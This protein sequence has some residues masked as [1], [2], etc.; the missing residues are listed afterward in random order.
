MR[1]ILIKELNHSERIASIDSLRLFAFLLVFLYHSKSLFPLTGWVGV[2][3]F[4]VISG[5]VVT[6]SVV[7]SDGTIPPSFDGKRFLKRRIRRLF[8]ASAMVLILTTPWVWY[9]SLPSERSGL[10]RSTVSGL[11]GF[12]N[13]SQLFGKGDY[14]SPENPSSFFHFWSLG[15]EE[16]FYL[17]LLALFV[18]ARGKETRRF[19]AAVW[20]LGSIS[21]LVFFLF[22]N[23]GWIGYSQSYLSTPH[24]LWEIVC[25]V[26]LAIYRKRISLK[27]IRWGT[28][29]LR[30]LN[31]IFLF[32]GFGL[33]LVSL[34]GIS[35]QWTIRSLVAAL[36]T[37]FIMTSL[38]VVGPLIQERG[39]LDYRLRPWF[40][41]VTS[42]LGR[43]TY[44]A[45]LWHVPV[46]WS[47]ERTISGNHWFLAVAAIT[48]TFV[49][50]DISFRYLEDSK[51]FNLR[52]GFFRVWHGGATVGIFLVTLFLLEAVALGTL[53]RDWRPAQT[54]RS[55]EAF[56]ERAVESNDAVPGNHEVD[57]LREERTQAEQ[58]SSQ[59]H[60][61]GPTEEADSNE[62]FDRTMIPDDLGNIASLPFLDRP[63]FNEIVEAGCWYLDSLRENPTRLF[64]LG[65]SHVDDLLPGIAH[66]AA[67]RE[68][69]ILGA[70]VFGGCPWQIDLAY[71]RFDN[72]ACRRF[73]STF[74]LEALPQLQGDV[75]LVG[76]HASTDW[77]FD[78]VRRSDSHKMGFASEE[79]RDITF[80]SM[81]KLL[82]NF[83][84]VV[85]MAPRSNAPFNIPD[86]LVSKEFVDEC[87]FA[88]S[89]S[90]EAEGIVLRALSLQ[91]ERI[92][93]VSI[94][95]LL[96]PNSECQSIIDG[97]RTRYDSNHLDP[98]FSQ[99]IGELMLETILSV[100]PA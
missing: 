78:L 6:S 22:S 1:E 11:F 58:V 29:L 26:I 49:F 2:D 21:F 69:V 75:V 93:Y 35:N 31:L 24:R 5:F 91:N 73:Q 87:S 23:N 27:T 99:E 71:E 42:W 36:G 95:E 81:E 84:H 56:T 12:N 66:A 60:Q 67:E 92:H 59:G 43:R 47:L 25:G 79:Y 16:Q 70:A 20:A 32:A 17:I 54:F 44:G 8:P 38:A 39:S 7:E 13:W 48:F 68:D 96:C 40:L 97:I 77:G 52:R 28:K 82:S 15:V 9:L 74:Y 46:L 51:A 3:I 94:N 33:V 85:L 10:L 37:L 41:A 65:D 50:A 98:R 80:A 62:D 90:V 88:A 61:S 45:Y 19:E 100:I 18:I 64:V 83:D 89:N 72:D 34:S 30:R 55:S 14:F 57:D 86:C 63:C 4:F 53:G 76:N